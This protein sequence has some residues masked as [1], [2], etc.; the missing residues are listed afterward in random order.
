MIN[1]AKYYNPKLIPLGEPVFVV[2]LSWIRGRVSMNVGLF[3]G[4]KRWAHG[5]RSDWKRYIFL[6]KEGEHLIS[7]SCE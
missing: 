2:V 3:S 7:P 1:P 6:T 4:I 5:V